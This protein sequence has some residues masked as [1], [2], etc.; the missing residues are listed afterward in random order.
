MIGGAF[1]GRGDPPPD[2]APPPPN[3]RPVPAPRFL[4]F[5]SSSSTCFAIFSRPLRTFFAPVRFSSTMIAMVDQFCVRVP[6][7]SF[8]RLPVLLLT[9]DPPPLVIVKIKEPIMR[10]RG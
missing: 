9:L 10:E 6:K 1:G 5:L 7:S 4:N 8:L 2:P 3:P